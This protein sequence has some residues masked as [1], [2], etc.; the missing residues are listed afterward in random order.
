VSDTIADY[1]RRSRRFSKLKNQVAPEGGEPSPLDA[2]EAD[3]EEED[4]GCPWTIIPE[5]TWKTWWD[6]A[7]ILMVIYNAGA[8]YLELSVVKL[9]GLCRAHRLF[10]CAVTL[11]VYLGFRTEAEPALYVLDWVVDGVFVIDIAFSFRT[12]T[13]HALGI[14]APFSARWQLHYVSSA[15]FL[16]R[17]VLGTLVCFAGYYT[18]EGDLVKDC[19]LIAE[20][21]LKGWC[22]AV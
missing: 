8:P 19:K 13:L 1:Q 9:Q 3:D 12:G 2:E 21:Y 5:S 14:R 10:F 11:P 7:V 20:R 22:V 6:V 4:K 17:H 15:P 16:T 18:P